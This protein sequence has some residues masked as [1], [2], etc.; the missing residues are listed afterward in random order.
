MLKYVIKNVNEGYYVGIYSGAH[1]FDEKTKALVF[2]RKNAEDIALYLKGLG[3][4]VEL[5]E[6]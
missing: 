2:L 5:E 6:E 1:R 4:K 3:H